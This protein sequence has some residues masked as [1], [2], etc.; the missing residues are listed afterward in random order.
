[1]DK[2]ITDLN[3]TA[4]NEQIRCLDASNMNKAHAWNIDGQGN[5]CQ[6]VVVEREVPFVGHPK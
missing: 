3:I 6:V 2:E 1:M 5:K 4:L